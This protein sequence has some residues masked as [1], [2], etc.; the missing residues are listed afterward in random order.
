MTADIGAD[1]SRALNGTASIRQL[2]MKKQFNRGELAINLSSVF[3][4]IDS[5]ENDTDSDNDSG[6]VVS[7]VMKRDGIGNAT[8]TAAEGSLGNETMTVVSQSNDPPPRN[9]TDQSP[10]TS[11]PSAVT[12][13][14]TPASTQ[15]SPSSTAPPPSTAQSAPN[16]TDAP[17]TGSGKKQKRGEQAC[18]IAV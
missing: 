15:S 2:V 13:Q 5:G 11:T 10:T 1:E 3:T 8:T 9:S 12:T 16:A 4:P 18:F 14:F 17:V 6:E 7:V